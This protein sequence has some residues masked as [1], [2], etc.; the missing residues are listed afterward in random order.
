[1]SILGQLQLL[2]LPFLPLSRVCMQPS[3][4][5]LHSCI[6]SLIQQRQSTW[7]VVSI[8]YL[9][10]VFFVVNARTPRRST[11]YTPDLSWFRF[12]YCHISLSLSRLL[13]FSHTKFHEWDRTE[14]IFF[15]SRD[16]LNVSCC[17][18]LR[19]LFGHCVFVGGDLSLH[20]LRNSS[21]TF[22]FISL[23]LENPSR[24][25]KFSLLWHGF[26]EFFFSRDS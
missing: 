13:L 16:L 15:F 11:S 25:L 4:V 10:S 1:M 18:S 3:F 21:S 23:R 2:L 22:F 20:R 5:S 8:K 26:K 14:N 17:W 7:L 19:G 12:I 9:S 24:M 6:T